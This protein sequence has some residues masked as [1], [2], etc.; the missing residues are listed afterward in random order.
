MTDDRMRELFNQA[1]HPSHMTEQRAPALTMDPKEL[2]ELI[3]MVRDR[4]KVLALPAM[5]DAGVTL[6]AIADVTA[7]IG[8]AIQERDEAQRERDDVLD[9]V[10]VIVNAVRLKEPAS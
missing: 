2:I 1:A 8:R 6:D 5:V 3:G 9:A 10:R 4:D 7:R